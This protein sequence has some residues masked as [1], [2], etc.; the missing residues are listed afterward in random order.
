MEQGQL[1]IK[2]AW[3]IFEKLKDQISNKIDRMEERIT[4]SIERKATNERVDKLETELTESLNKKAD[5]KFVV[6]SLVILFLILIIA[7]FIGDKLN[8]LSNIVF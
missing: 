4:V 3:E 2:E 7:I 1:S 5:V 6:L 8:L